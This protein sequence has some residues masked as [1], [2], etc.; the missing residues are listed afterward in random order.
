[1]VDERL[2]TAGS[3][4]NVAVTITAHAQNLTADQEGHFFKIREAS[5]ATPVTMWQHQLL[6]FL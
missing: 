4:G 6:Q 3:G 2:S 1:M 5:P